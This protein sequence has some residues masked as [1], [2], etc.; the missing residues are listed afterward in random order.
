M[1]GAPQTVDSLLNAQLPL[2]HAYDQPAVMSGKQ[3]QLVAR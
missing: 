2:T 1:V 3:P